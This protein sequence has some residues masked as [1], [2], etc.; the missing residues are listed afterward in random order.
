[1]TSH[2]QLFWRLTI[3]FVGVWMIA[4]CRSEKD[5]PTA[6]KSQ[7]TTH[8][9]AERERPVDFL[10]QARR[11]FRIGD[12]ESASE[13]AY[14]AL[15]QD[16]DSADAKLITSEIEAAR[17]NHQASVDLASSI[18]MRSRL[19]QR[20]F[21][22]RYRQLLKLKRPAEAADV[23]LAALKLG[24]IDDTRVLGWRRQAWIL[25]SRV[26][27]RQEASQQAEI[28]CRAGQA[29]RLEMASLARRNE[30]FPYALEKGGDPA[31][32]FEPGLGMA[33][34]YFTQRE[35]RRALEE[36]SHQRDAGFESPAACALY[37]RLLTQTQAIEAI[38]AWHAS[39]DE[40]VRNFS[41]YWVA[42]GTY[43][44]DQHQFEAS[45]KALLEAVTRDPT[46]PLCVN[47]L[48]KAFEALSQ[49]ETSEQFRH[50][51]ALMIQ[52]ESVVKETPPSQEADNGDS[53]RLVL[54]EL[55]R[56]FEAL[57]WMLLAIPESDADA[58]AAVAQKLAQLN[59]NDDA[60]EM[61]GQTA[62]V[63]IDPARFSLE[64]ALG[65]LRRSA[66]RKVPAAT[67]TD[68]L[69]VPRLVNVA[70]DVGLE[71]QWYQDVENNL[72]SIPLHEL[73]GG[74]IAIVDYDLD[75]W[76]DVYLSQGAGEP[77][78][79]ACTRSNVLFRNL[80]SQFEAITSLAGADD[81]NYASGLAAGDVNQD[82]FIDL[83]LGSLGR[84]RLL[85]NNGDG[86][87]RDASGVWGDVADRFTSSLAIA[88]ING[89]EMPDL[90]EAIYVEM[91]GAF[92]LPEIGDDGVP[93]QPSPILHYAQSDRWFE[94]LGNG[95]FQLQEITREVAMPGTSLGVVVTDFN[96]D[97][98]NEIF[99]GNDARTNHFL[100]Q[101]GDNQFV[102]TAGAKGVA[103][104]F[105][106]EADACMG[107]ATGDFD[108]DG[109]L[110]MHITNYLKESANL[111]LQS[112][113]GTFTDLA[114]RYGIDTF[115]LPYI[116]FGT[117]AVDVDR[118]RW[119]DLIVTN[120]HVF[121]LRVDGDELQMPPQ[122]LAN[123][124]DRFE[125]VSVE[126]DSGY[127]EGL[128]LGRS[129]AMTDFDRDGA[130]D[131]LIGHLHRPLALLHNQ[132]RS[133]GH[134]IQFE[135]VGTASERDAIGARIT[136][137]MAGGQQFTQWVT[138][139]DGYLCS[140][141]PMVDIGLG[142]L[143]E[144]DK[145]EVSWPTGKT[146]VFEGLEIG[147]RYL[148]VEGESNASAR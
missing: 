4:G 36:L 91:E 112:A 142:D 30:S 95:T 77:P 6:A 69:A 98:S 3:I 57:G 7:S 42:L 10:S 11:M 34:W 51:S 53:L 68:R 92:E 107:I 133:K 94:N 141:E 59:R 113:G 54:L 41:D 15:V 14:K 122:F 124:G 135:L 63:G 75:G 111:Y 106:G 101:A 88:D 105:S 86:T 5:G 65:M 108:R 71:F 8:D 49:P 104:G 93:L 115:T 43:F 136:V 132:T 31:K 76:P 117:K 118:N 145:V 19:G 2:P 74:G 67:H 16:P 130:I 82:G 144:L 116:G 137:T 90:F 120:G 35:Y 46:D 131:F 48:A 1:M 44:F 127:W 28:L 33:K 70:A 134:W 97:G 123:V 143:R 39:C 20:A 109:S 96:H 85:I 13:W 125:L 146:Q 103:C 89:D 83:L 21:E 23:I 25:L 24:P 119:L 40:Q 99:V 100:V 121:D 26:G 140:D 55:G 32:Y 52:L 87:F 73:M 138:A 56:P 38:P 102:N 72:T 81:F 61:A 62:L 37:G 17:G 22:L 18:E 139:G 50:R 27:R 12:L 66:P 129:I 126:D 58:R 79:D 110:D 128:Y 60:I 47:R 64:P 148:V 9:L 84:N 45:A 78:T 114:I 29:N 80:G 147:H